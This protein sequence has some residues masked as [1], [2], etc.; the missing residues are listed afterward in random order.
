MHGNKFLPH[1]KTIVSSILLLVSLL[2][3]SYGQ[4]KFGLTLMPISN[5]MV[6]TSHAKIIEER[7]SKFVLEAGY[8]EVV[9]RAILDELEKEKN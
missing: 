5:D 7:I 1:M 4:Q 9:E 6:L 3:I 2:S 8:F